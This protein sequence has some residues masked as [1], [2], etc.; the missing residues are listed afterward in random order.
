MPGVVG[1]AAAERALTISEELALLRAAPFRLGFIPKAPHGPLCYGR[2]IR[3]NDRA[4]VFV[5]L[6]DQSVKCRSSLWSDQTK[7]PRGGFCAG[8]GP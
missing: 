3:D 2:Y 8:R 6:F 1:G 5:F 7:R 4:G